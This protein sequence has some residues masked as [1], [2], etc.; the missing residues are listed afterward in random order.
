MQPRAWSHLKSRILTGRRPKE[1]PKPASGFGTRGSQIES[2]D[3]RNRVTDSAFVPDSI[4]QSDVRITNGLFSVNSAAPPANARGSGM[5]YS[6][7]SLDTLD[8]NELY[9]VLEEETSL[10]RSQNGGVQMD[11]LRVGSPPAASLNP[12]APPALEC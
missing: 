6:L 1:E 3:G 7:V 5:L 10:R 12:I 4:Q 8:D 9:D 11:E 2:S